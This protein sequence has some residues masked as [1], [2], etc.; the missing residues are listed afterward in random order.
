MEHTTEL[1]AARE[2]EAARGD[3]SLKELIALRQLDQKERALKLREKLEPQKMEIAWERLK[4]LQEQVRLAER[5]VALLEEK[6][7]LACQT[8][9]SPELTPEEK[10]ARLREIFGIQ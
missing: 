2:E 4:A 7:A 10:Q 8:L 1:L 6:Q 9:Q 3:L 5:R